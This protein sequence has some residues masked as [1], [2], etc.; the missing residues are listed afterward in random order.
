MGEG[1]LRRCPLQIRQHGPDAKEMAFRSSYF[2]SGNYQEVVDWESVFSHEAF[3]EH[4]SDGIASVVIGYRKPIKPFF[5][6]GL[7]ELLRIADPVPRKIG[8]AMEVE[9]N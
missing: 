3:V 1:E 2:D 5:A 8:V 4:V 7:D 6:G 9:L